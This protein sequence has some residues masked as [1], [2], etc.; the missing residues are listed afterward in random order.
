MKIRVFDQILLKFPFGIRLVKDILVHDTTVLIISIMGIKM[1]P[2]PPVQSKLKAQILQ[3]GYQN[4]QAG[5]NFTVER[6]KLKISF[7]HHV[8]IS[9]KL[10]FIFFRFFKA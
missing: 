1:G 10:L 7:Y 8:F 6:K 2:M 3:M 5:S 4:V 9:Q